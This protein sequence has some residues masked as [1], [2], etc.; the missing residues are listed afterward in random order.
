[1]GHQLLLGAT[2]DWQLALPA[3]QA[4]SRDLYFTNTCPRKS[5]LSTARNACQSSSSA[6]V[7][8]WLGRSAMKW[9]RMV[10]RLPLRL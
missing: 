8:V 4:M 3:S 7:Q 9:R 5:R 10:T 2:A 6:G 1:M